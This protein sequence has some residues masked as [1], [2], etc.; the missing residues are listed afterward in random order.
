MTQSRCRCQQTLLK[1]VWRFEWLCIVCNARVARYSANGRTQYA[2]QLN[3]LGSA[4]VE[5]ASGVQYPSR[6]TVCLTAR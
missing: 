6:Q 2:P 1:R 4:A 5:R 3:V